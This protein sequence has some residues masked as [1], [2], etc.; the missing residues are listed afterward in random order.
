MKTKSPRLAAVIAA[1]LAGIGGGAT[2]PREHR[3]ARIKD[4]VSTAVPGRKLAR[5]YAQRAVP[6]SRKPVKV[7]F[8]L[9]AMRYGIP[10][11][12]A[13]WEWSVAKGGAR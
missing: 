4:G 10:L 12:I 13:R 7:G 6:L 3:A 9:R 1:V 8:R 11:T 2:V 5:R